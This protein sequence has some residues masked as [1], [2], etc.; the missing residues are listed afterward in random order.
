MYTLAEYICSL[1]SAFN[2][3]TAIFIYWKDK[4]TG[5]TVQSGQN[6]QSFKIC[7]CMSVIFGLMSMGIMMNNIQ[8][9]MALKSSH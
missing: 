9:E 7:I 6:F 1:I 8:S 2:L 5:H 4:R 3:C